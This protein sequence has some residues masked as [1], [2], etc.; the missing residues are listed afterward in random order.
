MAKLGLVAPRGPTGIGYLARRIARCLPVSSWLVPK[1]GRDDGYYDPRMVLL[2]SGSLEKLGSFLQQVDVILSIERC[3]P[4]DLFAQAGGRR[5]ALLVMGEWFDPALGAQADLLI[6]PTRLC[7]DRLAQLG[8]GAKTYY[9]PMPLDLGEFCFRQRTVANRFVFCDGW[10]GVQERKGSRAVEQALKIA[11][12][13]LQVRSQRTRPW[14]R[15]TEVLGPANEPVELY[16]EA[17]V[18]V[19]PSRWEGLGLQQLEAMACGVPVVVPDAPPMNEHCQDA[20]GEEADRLLCP[21]EIS[22]HT[23][24]FIPWPD[25]QCNGGD[26]VGVIQKLRGSNVSGLG[27]Q[28][29]RYVEQQHGKMQWEEFRSVLL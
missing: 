14:P 10:G 5:K 25:A 11:P 17:D 28:A 9:L 29:R 23:V 13:L 24:A 26:L 16:A 4:P 12:S 15:G 2:G 8:F 1:H 22:E 19:Q 3:W 20:H 27:L 21:C 7:R 6:A 18:C